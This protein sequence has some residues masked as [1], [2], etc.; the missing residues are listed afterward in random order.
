MM[1]SDQSGIDTS[2]KRLAAINRAIT[3]S[4]N[5]DEVLGVI[6]V[7]AAELFDADASLLLLSEPDGTLRVRAVHGSDNEALASFS[8]RMEEAV[9]KDLARLLNL[10]PNQHLLTTPVISDGAL[11]G[12]LAIVR[13]SPLSQIEQWQMSALADQA[14]IALKNARFHELATRTALRERDESLAA[15]RESNLKINRI[16]SS[17]TDLFY[18]L[19]REWRFVEV[20]K[21]VEEMFRKSRA[22]LIGKVIWEVFPRAVESDLY[23]NFHKAMKEMTPTHSEVASKIVPGIWFEAQTYPSATGLNVY[24]RDITERKHAEITNSRLAAI[25]ES[26]DDAII[27]KDLNGVIHTWNKGAERIFGYTAAEAIGQPVTMLIPSGRINE[28]PA[29]LEQIRQ[30][31]QVE[32]YETVRQ[33]KDGSLLDISLTISPIKDEAGQIIGA[34]KIARDIS[35][36]RQRNEESR[37]QAH[38]LG[39]VE[40]AVIATDLEGVVT[41]WNS[42]AEKLYGWS[43]EEAVGQSV[44]ELTPS[45]DEAKRAEEIFA[46]L[47][48]GQSWS[49]E[50]VVRRKDGTTFP[51]M[52]TDWPITDTS[53]ALVGVVGVSE[54]ITELKEAEAERVRLLQAEREARADAEAAN[55]LKDEFLATLSH[56]LRNPL[57]VILGY[58]EILLRQEQVEKST[59]L[60]NAVETL[61]RN[62]LAQSLLVRDL[63]DLS[64]LHMG[65]LSLAREVVSFRSVISNAVETVTAEAATKNIEIRVEVA[66]ED[67]MVKADSL[68][69]EQVVWNLLNNAVKFT[70]P[71]GKVTIGLTREGSEAVLRV[72]DTGQGIDPEFL[73]EVFDMFR[74]A[75]A[76]NSR[77]HGGMGIGLALVRQLVELH[78]GT[79]TASSDGI[80]CGATFTVQIPLS[81]QAK[82]TV[83][84]AETISSGLLDN[85]QVLIVDDSVDTVEM[86]HQLLELEGAIV[87][88]AKSGAEALELAAQK[89]FDVVVSDISMPRM[90]GFEFLRRLRG[91]PGQERVP[92]LALTGFGRAEDIT[93]AKAE[94]F[95][96]HVTKPVDVDELL[97]ILRQLPAREQSEIGA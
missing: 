91:I 11:N 73:P 71:R 64:R 69:M 45:A 10:E 26:S 55:A 51:A 31:R 23:P 68:R 59:F 85:L 57:N 36:R 96:S 17:I 46:R 77:K 88:S 60:K 40:Q 89:H 34:S 39:A 61:R 33:R 86:L 8:G 49:G 79:A 92:V 58:S 95:V 53:G 14:A 18:Q 44:F 75:D 94:G 41:Y 37:F 54:D 2:L 6:V 13:G 78:G 82:P 25:V 7:N 24:L 80:G 47:R 65:K 28:E 93:R 27:S 56:E 15:L 20:N 19:D 74:Q 1:D 87:S 42:F 30:G 72:T 43:A 9:I 70:D 81:H 21:R 76:S 38:L 63:L 22:E 62:A 12:F 83:N 5:F 52:V 66:P 97:E 90:D 32:H 4:L 35:E 16:L 3:T 50:F 84:T 29:I 67:C 48:Q